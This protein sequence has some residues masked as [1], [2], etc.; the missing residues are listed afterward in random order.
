M[1]S[2]FYQLNLTILKLVG[3]LKRLDYKSMT[4]FTKNAGKVL[5]LGKRFHS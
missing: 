5:R 2:S 3:G 4:V 1:P